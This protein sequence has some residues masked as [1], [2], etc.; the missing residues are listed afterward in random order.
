[1]QAP[2]MK[3]GHSKPTAL[4]M[5]A[6]Y[7][8]QD[9]IRSQVE[10]ILAQEGVDVTLLVCDDQSSDS[11]FEIC[12]EYAKRFGNVRVSQNAQNQGAIR[13]FM[14][15]VWSPAA[16]GYDLYAFSD[17]DDQ[18]FPNKLS[19]AASK[20]L[21]ATH[22]DAP[23]LYFSDIQNEWVDEHDTCI[24]SRREISRFRECEKAPLTPL[25]FNWVNGC[26]MV[27]NAPLRNLLLKCQPA[28]L[29]R[30][31]DAW[32]HMVARYCG[33]IVADYDTVLMR[34]RITG[35]NTVGET[36]LNVRTPKQY[37]QLAK[38]T[39]SKREHIMQDCARMLLLGYREHIHPEYLQ[40]IE[41]FA[42]YRSSWKNRLRTLRNRQYWR[43]SVQTRLRMRAAM[44]IGFY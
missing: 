38:L 22:R 36:Q 32:V 5:V 31:H 19:V 11:T 34:R 25:V 15:M 9:F 7:N 3:T 2:Q 4:V 43:P 16:D 40:P 12:Q 26:A 24:R 20:L 41:E 29:P 23:T 39:F 18:W 13:N 33:S 1:M 14:N 42:Y 28:A 27:F 17:Q 44:L 21:S 6:T 35:T 10:S 37:L 30:Y 8:G